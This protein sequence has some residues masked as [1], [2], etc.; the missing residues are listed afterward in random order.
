MK[1]TTFFN[2]FVNYLVELM[3]FWLV[4]SCFFIKSLILSL[5]FGAGLK[6]VNISYEVDID[7]FPKGQRRLI[8]Q[9]VPARNRTGF[10]QGSTIPEAYDVDDLYDYMISRKPYSFERNNFSIFSLCLIS[11]CS[12]KAV[13]WLPVLMRLRFL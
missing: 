13:I 9:A 12:K 11:I 3:F 5:P 2:F 7:S 8:A 10:A 1:K 6:G 4:R